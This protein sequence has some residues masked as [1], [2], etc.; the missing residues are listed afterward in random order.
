MCPL[1]WIVKK[2]K[3]W[4]WTAECQEAFEKIK[5]KLTS[6]LF[7]THYNP[8]LD[9]IVTSDT[10]SY[11]VGASIQ[12]MTDGTTKQIA[13]VLRG[14]LHVEKNYSQIEKEALGIIFTVSKFHCFI[15]G[16]HFTLQTDHKPLVTIFGSNKSLLLTQP[17]DCRDGVQSCL[18][19]ISKW[20]T[21]P[22][23]NSAM[24]T[25]YQG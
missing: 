24:R 20:C 16:W 11:G 3:P 9:I 18:I 6:D 12:Q 13:Y 4:V 17:K 14:L 10:I 5:K 19:I 25:D 21:Y 23:I 2:D 15:H 8:D 22:W 7:L 1:Q